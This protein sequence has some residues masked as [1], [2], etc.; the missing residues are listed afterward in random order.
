MKSKNID[1]I[2]KVLD[3][4]DYNI[5][6][7]L[8]EVMK[9]FNFQKICLQTGFIK[10]CGY[11][12]LEVITVIIMM[13]LMLLKSVNAFYNSN[14]QNVTEMKK[15]VIYR[16]KNNENMKWRQLQYRVC[17]QFQKLTNKSKEINPNS[18]FIIDDTSSI[19]TGK[20]IENIS[21]IHNHNSTQKS[22]NLGF[23]TL[24]LGFFDG[25]TMLPLD[26]S[27]HSEKKL[28]QKDRKNQYKKI[29]TKNSEG[30][31][32]RKECSVDKITNALVM[33]KR[34][35]KNGFMAKY[36]LADSWFTSEKFI[37]EIRKIKQ[38]LLH[39]I[40]GIKMDKRKYD[41]KNQ[42]IT[43]KELLRI[44][45]QDGKVKRCRKWNIRYFEVVVGYKSIDSLK[46]YF[47]RF[48]YQKTWR[49]FVST[50]VNLNFVQMMEIYKIR[51]VIE[52]FF[53]EV[54]QY[55]QFGKCQSRDF[56]AQIASIT[57]CFLLYTFLA[58][59]RWIS[60]YKTLGILFKTINDDIC[61]KSVAER[62]WMIF[63]E[64]I[65]VIITSIS[66]SGSIDILQF[67]KSKEF[68]QVKEFFEGSFLSTQIFELTKVA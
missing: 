25:K 13:P 41:Y 48:P 4:N 40:A 68:I 21:I 33:I 28:K 8:Y 62:L 22:F 35:V 34:A 51:W 58:Y 39:V 5:N 2:K 3:Q 29:C 9:S 37:K 59:Y 52:V 60:A 7:I 23:K 56:D 6:N 14:Y 11:E 55:L 43:G 31:K 1:E 30:E 66:K 26:F 67:K 42:K 32:R 17:K 57:L 12:L 15:D 63:E 38:G 54:K 47:C 46:L 65:D 10:E 19:K 36:V 27:I 49:I 45:K 16:L 24:V 50:D 61:E 64:F 44:L 20:T 53:K 18:A